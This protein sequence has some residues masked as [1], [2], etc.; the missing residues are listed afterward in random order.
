MNKLKEERFFHIS[1][2]K[3]RLNCLKPGTS[4]LL[5][6]ISLTQIP[7]RQLNSTSGRFQSCQD[8]AGTSPQDGLGLSSAAQRPPHSSTCCSS[9]RMTFPAAPNSSSSLSPSPIEVELT[10]KNCTIIYSMQYNYLIYVYIMKG[11]PPS[12]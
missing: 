3:H 8:F 4:S 5:R 11:F 2:F 12:R 10:N 6:I 9:W 1:N 7:W